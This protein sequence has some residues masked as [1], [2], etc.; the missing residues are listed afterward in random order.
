MQ[1][2]KKKLSAEEVK[3]IKAQKEKE[4]KQIVKK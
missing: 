3:K 1:Y 4:L 2:P